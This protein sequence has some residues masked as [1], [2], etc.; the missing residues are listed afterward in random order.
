[1]APT[2]PPPESC[3]LLDQVALSASLDDLK[4]IEEIRHINARLRN[5]SLYWYQIAKRLHQ[6]GGGKQ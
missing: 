4:T 1:M 5:L 6:E 3:P 2:T